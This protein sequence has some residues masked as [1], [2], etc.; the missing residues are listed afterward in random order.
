MEFKF[1]PRERRLRIRTLIPADREPR[2]F[3][4]DKLFQF[5]IEEEYFLADCETFEAPA[6]TPDALFQTADCRTTGRIGREF[7]QAQIEVATE[8]HTSLDDARIGSAPLRGRA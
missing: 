5:G 7:L 6:E 2:V 1:D 4:P 3:A 8:P